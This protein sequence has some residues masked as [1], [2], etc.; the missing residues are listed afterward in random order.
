METEGVIGRGWFFAKDDERGGDDE[1]YGGC[2]E[3]GLIL[4]G[5]EGKEA[6]ESDEGCEVDDY[7]SIEGVDAQF[8]TQGQS[9]GDGSD[10]SKSENAVGVGPSGHE[11]EDE[12]GDGDDGGD[13]SSG[14]EGG[15]FVG[16]VALI[17]KT[18]ESSHGKPAD[19]SEEH[20][21]GRGSGEWG[22]GKGEA[23]ENSHDP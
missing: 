15:R 2:A 7:E 21:D 12:K 19:D 13:G 16:A 14:V 6:D 9:G 10:D 17:G 20:G 3:K 22:G 23:G 18:V 1:G 4:E 8:F 5:R 11:A